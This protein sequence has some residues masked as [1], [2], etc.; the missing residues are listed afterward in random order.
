MK[1]RIVIGAVVAVVLVCLGLAIYRVNATS[2]AKTEVMKVSETQKDKV[3]MDGEVKSRNTKSFY[4][5]ATKGTVETIN[6]KDGDPV[7]SGATLYKYKNEAVIDQIDDLNRQLSSAKKSRDS[8]RSAARQAA[9]ATGQQTSTAPADT[10][11]IDGQISSLESQIKSLED[12][13]YEEIKAP[14]DGRVTLNENVEDMTTP[15]VIINSIDSYISASVS[16]KDYEKIYA[17]DKVDINFTA[18]KLTS[19]GTIK[20]VGEN[21]IYRQVMPSAA[22]GVTASGLET[23]TLSNY[24]VDI[25][26]NEKPGSN[27]KNGFHLQAVK[28]TIDRTVKVPEAAIIRENKQAY[29]FKVVNKKLKKQ[30]VKLGEIKGN[31][32]TITSGIKIGDS[33]VKNPNKKMKDGDTVE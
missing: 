17:G 19:T 1:K 23:S 12:K 24:N 11:Q 9:R 20:S 13:K 3:F 29:C 28:S 7:K 16:E 22:G 18:V 5:D 15:F 27:I 31:T 6:V 2:T 32:V 33:I 30:N 21:P 4:K 26:F 8:I 25:E 14:F 10:S